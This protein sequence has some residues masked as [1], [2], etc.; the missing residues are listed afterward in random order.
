MTPARFGHRRLLPTAT[1][2]GTV[3]MASSRL[4]DPGGAKRT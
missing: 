2:T 3:G 1:A 4:L